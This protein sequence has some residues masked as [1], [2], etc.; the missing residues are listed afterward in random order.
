MVLKRRT[1][2]NPTRNDAA[3]HD[4]HRP[5]GAVQVRFT[6][7]EI[8]VRLYPEQLLLVRLGIHL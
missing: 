7:A 8:A 1:F 3:R 5:A 2:R 4:R 6:R